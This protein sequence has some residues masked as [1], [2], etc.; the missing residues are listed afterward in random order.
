[1]REER[2]LC[3]VVAE[4]PAAAGALEEAGVAEHLS[5]AVQQLLAAARDMW[6]DGQPPEVGS[7]EYASLRA[8]AG[9]PEIANIIDNVM[10]GRRMFDGETVEK[11]IKDFIIRA[12]KRQFE[13]RER[14]LLTEL[15]DSDRRGDRDGAQR[16]M[17]ALRELRNAR[18][19]LERGVVPPP[20]YH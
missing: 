9:H 12:R 6:Q 17:V 13:K 11:A 5:A 1:T 16:A 10:E 8:V 2:D 20:T 18:S 15:Q 14:E 7:Q 4:C 3:H 19:N